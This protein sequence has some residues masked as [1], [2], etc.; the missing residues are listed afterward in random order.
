LAVSMMPE[1]NWKSLMG[2]AILDAP[3]R[4]NF[5]HGSPN[6]RHLRQI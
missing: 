3:K 1:H 6:Q 5:D 4:M 2:F